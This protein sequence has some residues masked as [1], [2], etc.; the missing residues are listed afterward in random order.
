MFAL[1][2][3]MTTNKQPIL[4]H[5]LTNPPKPTSILQPRS[6]NPQSATP[7][8]LRSS[9]PSKSSSLQVLWSFQLPIRPTW[10]PR[11]NPMGDFSAWNLLRA[12]WNLAG[13]LVVW[14]SP[15]IFLGASRAHPESLHRPSWEPHGLAVSWELPGSAQEAPP[16]SLLAISWTGSLLD[17]TPKKAPRASWEAAECFEP[18]VLG[19]SWLIPAR[20]QGISWKSA[21]NLLED[22]LPGSLQGTPR[23]PGSIRE[24]PGNLQGASWERSGNLLRSA[25]LAMRAMLL[26]ESL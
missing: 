23:A 10:N 6:T 19:D 7:P 5:A 24:S 13:N 11:G 3:L 25:D 9:S 4:N 18:A 26:T 20:L 8:T 12:S 17:W 15:G 16:E 22:S 2:H 1:N 14:E 21:R